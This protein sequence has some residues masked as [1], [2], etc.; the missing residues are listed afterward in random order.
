[1]LPRS[2]SA[3]A[4]SSDSNPTLADELSPANCWTVACSSWMRSWWTRSRA[5][6]DST[7]GVR[8]SAGISGNSSFLQRSAGKHALIG[9]AKIRRY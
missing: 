7:N 9:C 6:R 5:S 8:S 3:A 4:H 1:M 2:R